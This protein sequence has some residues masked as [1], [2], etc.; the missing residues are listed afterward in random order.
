MSL[1][2]A[3]PPAQY[4]VRSHPSAASATQAWLASRLCGALGLATP[5]AILVRGCSLA[6]DGIHDPERL[7]LATPFLPAYESLGRWLEGDAAWRV[8]DGV[9]GGASPACGQAR[10]EAR[11]LGRQVARLA[12]AV[13]P[14]AGAAAMQARN[15]HRA[16]LYGALPDVYQCALERHRLAA[17]WLDNRDLFDGDMGNLGIWRDKNDLPYAMT[18]DFTGCLGMAATPAG[19]P[20]CLRSGA[21]AMLGRRLGELRAA[22]WTNAMPDVLKDPVGVY[23]LAA[24]MAYRLGRIGTSDILPWASV[25]SA[26]TER[27]GGDG[28]GDAPHARIDRILA[29]RDS[30]VALLGGT[31]AAQTWARM[32]PTRAAAIGAQQSRFLASSQY[33]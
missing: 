14:Q 31:N 8:I 20:R 24:E 12:D 17:M 10:T 19:A 29:R 30:L 25:V 27:F 13:G 16:V 18:V 6:V 3:G 21:S 1:P 15:A 32:Y 23:A 7:Y 26:L 5:T 9:P 2:S 11:E 33:P 22:D 4:V 28:G